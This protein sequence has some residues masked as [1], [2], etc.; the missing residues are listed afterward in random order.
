M[1][2]YLTTYSVTEPPSL[3]LEFI[4]FMRNLIPPSKFRPVYYLLLGTLIF[5]AATTTIVKAHSADETRNNA[6]AS[7]AAIGRNLG[8]VGA[9]PDGGTTRESGRSGPTHKQ[10]DWVRINPE[11]ERILYEKVKREGIGLRK[12]DERFD[13]P[14]ARQPL[15]AQGEPIDTRFDAKGNSPALDAARANGITIANNRTEHIIGTGGVKG[16]RVSLG[17]ETRI[18]RFA[19]GI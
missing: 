14:A 1:A 15:D 9:K 18:N 11:Q 3:S 10:Q 13:G 2:I 5:L 17:I 16:G 8:G 19:L 12:F 6:V 7:S 4:K